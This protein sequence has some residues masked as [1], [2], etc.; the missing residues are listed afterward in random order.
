MEHD[1]LFKRQE[2]EEAVAIITT[3][4]SAQR[5]NLAVEEVEAARQADSDLTQKNYIKKKAL[6][7]NS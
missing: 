5:V 3:S 2:E 4:Q 6:L 1:Y 7:P